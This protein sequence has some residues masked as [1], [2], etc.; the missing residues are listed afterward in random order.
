MDIPIAALQG[1]VNTQHGAIFAIV[2]QHGCHP[3]VGIIST[4]TRASLQWCRN[5]ATN[6]AM[7]S[8]DTRFQFLPVCFSSPNAPDRPPLTT[9]PVT[10]VTLCPEMQ[11]AHP[12]KKA[13]SK[14]VIHIGLSSIAHGRPATPD[15]GSC[16]TF[17]AFGIFLDPVPGLEN[18]LANYL[19]DDVQLSLPL[20]MKLV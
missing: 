16:S 18:T 3:N 13:V 11:P 9:N 14:V 10:F 12:Y 19:M 1:V 17:T 5:S 7:A 2:H 20:E 4:H 8:Y 15:T 6:L